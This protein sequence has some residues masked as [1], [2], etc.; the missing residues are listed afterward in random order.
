MSN[1]FFFGEIVSD[2]SDGARLLLDVAMR[3]LSLFLY[4]L[5]PPVLELDSL[6]A[7]V[8]LSGLVSRVE[9][10]ASLMLSDEPRAEAG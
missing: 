7:Y 5:C 8:F 2:F 1:T 3:R 4:L 9:T 10:T 6:C